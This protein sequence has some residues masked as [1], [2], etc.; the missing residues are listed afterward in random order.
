MYL[1]KKDHHIISDINITADEVKLKLKNLD[2][3]KAT[4]P[5]KIPS[6]ILKNLSDELSTPLATLFN[7]S[8]KE[9]IVPLIWKTAEITAIFKKGDKTNPTNYRP[10]SLTSIICKILESLITDKI[11]E[12]MESNSFFLKLPTWF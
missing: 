7:K 11:R 4:G 3:H 8:I 12:Y 1:Q 2:I 9:G 10:V 5:D 6:I